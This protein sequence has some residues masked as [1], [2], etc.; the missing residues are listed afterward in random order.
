ML[1]IMGCD[2]MPPMGI[3]GQMPVVTHFDSRPLLRA[4]AMPQSK[5]TTALALQRHCFAALQPGAKGQ[6]RTP[7]SPFLQTCLS[8]MKQPASP[9]ILPRIPRR[10]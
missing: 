2:R 4:A 5:L 9:N 10:I 1:H 8:T 3:R 7:T 6:A